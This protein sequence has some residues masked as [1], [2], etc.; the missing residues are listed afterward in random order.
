[1]NCVFIPPKKNER[2]KHVNLETKIFSLEELNIVFTLFT[3]FTNAFTWCIQ[4]L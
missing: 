4:K 1:M 2:Q 3:L